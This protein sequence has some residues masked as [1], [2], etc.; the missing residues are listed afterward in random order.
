MLTLPAMVLTN[1]SLAFGREHGN[2]IRTATLWLSLAALCVLDREHVERLSSGRW[3]QSAVLATGGAPGSAATR[4]LC[5]NHDDGQTTAVVQ[6]EACGALCADCDR[7]LHLSRKTR[8][9]GRTVCKEEEE[10]IRVELHESCGRTKLF[11]LLAL[12][13]SRTLKAMVE[14]RDRESAL[15]GGGSGDGGSGECLVAISIRSLTKC[16][17]NL[18]EPKE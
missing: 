14:F 5:A 1:R 11:W 7:F 18:F 10:A 6:C 3:T 8:V 12:A 9:H 16:N 2:C 13:D 15:I 17:L 4:P